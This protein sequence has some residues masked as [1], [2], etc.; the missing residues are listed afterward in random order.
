[1][2]LLPLLIIFL[3]LG[4]GFQIVGTDPFIPAFEWI[5]S[6][7]LKVL[8][9]LLLPFSMLI[10]QFLPELDGA[11]V[12]LSQYFGYASTYMSW[13]MSAFAVPTLAV[14]LLAT[15]YLFTFTVSI[16]TYSFKLLLK[17]KRAVL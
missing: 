5:M 16:S 14:T 7:L 15:Y 6:F 10:E 8:D 11:L 1:M 12:A 9:F 17:W 4:I 3:A 13:I 2:I